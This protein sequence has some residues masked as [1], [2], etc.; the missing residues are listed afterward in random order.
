MSKRATSGVGTRP[1]V[2]ERT[3]AR[4]RA[5]RGSRS[6]RAFGAPARSAS[7][8]ALLAAVGLA[9]ACAREP[10]PPAVAKP[11]SG[12]AL[13][14]SAGCSDEELRRPAR[15]TQVGLATYYHDSLSGNLTASGVPYEPDLFT[16]AHRKL[17]FGTRV[18]VTRTD[19]SA[20]SV[21]VTVNDR[22][23]FAGEQRIIDVSRRAA[24]QL[25][26]TGS[27]VVP[28]RIEIL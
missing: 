25:R 14:G 7:L 9:W 23:P 2:S 17:P 4:S 21:C 24:E 8:W 27:G 11:R 18:R 13:P 26:M 10:L 19:A 28:V 20:P 6:H 15:E 12:V 1:E 5:A 16:A 3:H 22:G